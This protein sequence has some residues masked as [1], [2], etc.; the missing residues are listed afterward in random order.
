MNA[1]TEEKVS[2]HLLR[3]T[4]EVAAVSGSAIVAR[5][6]RASV[7]DLCYIR[8]RVGDHIAAQVIGFN[9]RTFALAP[10]SEPSGIY[11]GAQVATFGFSISI[12]VGECLK[13]RVINAL[14]APIDR[15]PLLVPGNTHRPVY[16]RSQGP[17][18]RPLI[19]TVLAT[20][21]RA[22]D[23]FCTLGLGQ[24]IGV[25][26]SAGVGKSTLLGMLARNAKIDVIVVA[27]VGERGREVREFIDDTLGR[28]GLERSVV[29]VATS[30]EPS[31]MRQIAPYTAT[32]I[33]EYFRDS[34]K[35]VLL[36]IDSLTRMARAVRET[37]LAAGELPVRHGY[38]TSV[39]TELPKLLERAGTNSTGSITS[40]CTVLTNE[41]DDIDPLADEVKSLI[42]GHIVLKKDFASRG[43]LPAIDITQSISRLFTRLNH[44]EYISA[45]RIVISA[46][47]RLVKEREIV[48]MGGTPDPELAK[49]ISMEKDLFGLIRQDS[50][51]APELDR[52]RHTAAALAL[53]LTS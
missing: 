5:L 19:D 31:M 1:L 20:G 29:V 6:P 14:G 36:I 22:I 37:S 52:V 25:F 46:L 32:T 8:T 26:A 2:P 44:P 10:L 3:V 23:G 39:Y 15:R 18:D 47:T 7:G 28:T 27:L 42:D 21:I 9:D 24:R 49:I 48:L 43:I 50:N 12:P 53:R 45:A 4:G 11:P 51:E 34:G 17:S 40:F 30:D 13:G 38:T 35:N 33:A 16:G 41:E